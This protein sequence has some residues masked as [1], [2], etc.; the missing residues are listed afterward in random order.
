MAGNVHEWVVDRGP[1]GGRHRGVRGGGLENMPAAQHHFVQ[2][3][4]ARDERYR[5]FAVG[6]R[7]AGGLH[8]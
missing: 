6:L 5:D 7:C 2:Y 3:T 1:Q 4:N 8:E